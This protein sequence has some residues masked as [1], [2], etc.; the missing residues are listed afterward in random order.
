VGTQVLEQSLDC[1]F[2]ALISDLAPVDLLFQRAGRVHRHE[3]AKDARGDMQVPQVFVVGRETADGMPPRVPPGSEIVYGHHLLWRT[4]AVLLGRRSL[5]IPADVPRLVDKVYGAGPVG[6]AAWQAVMAA[7]ADEARARK[8][9]MA[10]DAGTIMIPLPSA[11]SLAAIHCR[12]NVGDAVDEATPLVQ[13]H[14]RIGPPTIEVMLLRRTRNA[15]VA[16]TVS[17]GVPREIPLDRVPDGDTTDVALDQLIRLPAQVTSAAAA[18]ASPRPAWSRSPWL[19][20]IPVLLLPDDSG[21]LRLGRH[22]CT[23]SPE[24]GLEV[25]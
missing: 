18:A 15:A 6:P 14:V 19:A 9:A 8:D 5:E 1:D 10:C 25:N 21:P 4:E 17:D 24:L 23:Y 13:A 2:D 12:A 11:S 22:R 16:F 20:R 7:A 3:R